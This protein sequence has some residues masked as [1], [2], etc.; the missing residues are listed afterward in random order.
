MR[1]LEK[2]LERLL[3]LLGLDERVKRFEN[4]ILRWF[5]YLFYIIIF[6]R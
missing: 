5:W 1:V 6:K 3:E 4:I 2:L